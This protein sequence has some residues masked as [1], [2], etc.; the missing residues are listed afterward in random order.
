M[1]R[2]LFEDRGHWYKGNLHTHTQNSDGELPFDTVVDM[3]RSNGYDFMAVTD[4]WHLNQT[5][6]EK[7]FLLLNGA[8]WDVNNP[9]FHIVGFGLERDPGIERGMQAEDYI[10]RINAAGG[11]AMLAH[12]AW[13]LMEPKDIARC[14]GVFAAEIYNTTSGM[15]WNPERADSSHYFDL[16]AMN[17]I[18]MNAVADDDAHHYNGDEMKS[19]VMV[20]AEDLSR[21]SVLAALREGNFYASQG[22]QILDAVWDDEERTLTLQC[23][24]DTETVYFSSNRCWSPDRV[25]HPMDGM[26]LFHSVPKETYLRA[27]LI[28]DMG[29]KAWL[30][31][32]AI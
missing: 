19:F 22:P 13:S 14:E 5:V 23:S 11:L 8:E 18:L 15:P 30:S 6:E 2:H 3:Y 9:V 27:T 7:D 21:K 31:P 4:H 25:Q 28:D 26:A 16:W 29:R 24:E 1:K 12:P 32:F 17:G 10:R 20:N